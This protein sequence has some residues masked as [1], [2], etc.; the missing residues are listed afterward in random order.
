M[1]T[2]LQYADG[3]ITNSHSTMMSLKPMLDASKRNLVRAVAHLGTH[4]RESP[5]SRSVSGERPYFVCVGTIEPRNNHMLLLHVWRRLSE[6][7]GADNVPKLIVIGRRGWENEQI[8]DLLERC[9]ALK[10]CVEEFNHM[11]DVQAAA[12]LSGAQALLLPSFAEGYGMPVTEALS[13]KVPVLCSDLPSLREAGSN[14]PEFLDPLDGPA[15][16]RAILDYT[17]NRHERRAQQM[18]RLTSWTAPSWDDHIK[19]VLSLSR[20]IMA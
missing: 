2:V 1:G 18:E 20:K 11:P 17:D 10:G 19:I 13:L 9:T 16:S 6:R 5:E 4:I 12:L 15:W 3:I 14:V 7:F 8:V